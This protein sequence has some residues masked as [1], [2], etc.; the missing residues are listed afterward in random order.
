M[1]GATKPR[2]TP[3]GAVNP[4]LLRTTSV[5]EQPLADYLV[6]APS[7]PSGLL[8]QRRRST[9]H[10]PQAKRKTPTCAR[11]APVPHPRLRTRPSS[12]VLRKHDP[13]H[14]R[15]RRRPT[16]RPGAGAHSSA[17]GKRGPSGGHVCAMADGRGGPAK[18]RAWA[19]S[20][21]AAGWGGGVRPSYRFMICIQGW[22]HGGCRPHQAMP[23]AGAYIYAAGHR[24]LLGTYA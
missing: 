15:R 7:I 18:G 11:G 21:A 12:S 22:A 3:N 8:P 10:G 5:R 16:V 14:A 24:A 17:S 23:G 9:H 4:T 1:T 19:A 2:P 13:N 20:A 6:E